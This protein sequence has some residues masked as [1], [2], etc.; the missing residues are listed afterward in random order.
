VHP[1]PPRPDV[2]PTQL[3]VDLD[4]LAANLRWVRARAPGVPVLAVLKANA[5]GHGLVP[6]GRLYQHLGVAYL[7]V[8]YLEEGIE[9]R[10]AGITTPILVMGGIT[11][12]Q[13]PLF[14]NHD[15]TL[16]ASSV[17]KLNAIEECAKRL[18]RRAKVHLK[19]DTGMERIGV[20]WYSCRD[21]LERSLLCESVEVEGIYSHLASSEGPDLTHAREQVRRFENALRFYDERGLRPPLRHLANSGG[22]LN[23]P[24]S[25]LDL[26]RP[27]LLLYGYD[28]RGA[29][30]E[31]LKSAL[32]WTTRV[33]YFKVV[34]AKSPVSY[35][36]TYRPESMTRMVTLPVGYGD[37]YSRRMSGRAQVL[38]GGRRYPVAGTICMD[39][40][41]V[42]IGW[43]SAYN[44]DEVVLLGDQG[45]ARITAEEFAGWSD[46]ITYEALTSIHPRVPRVYAGVIA[47]EL[48][49][50]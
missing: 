18:S 7:G 32:R 4:Q 25:H 1:S 47:A 45:E 10:Q 44:G 42:D 24:E 43:D 37:G 11:D 14:L 41:V 17:A 23:L 27:G 5:Y 3:T 48:G 16:T 36:G 26:I 49:L 19:I 21:L 2:R 8:A 34:Q 50:T 35:G 9:L 15:L 46:T 20:H 22:L 6:M 31:G 12:T 30:H 39:Q 40:V 33:V 28:P 38:I 13:I 29:H